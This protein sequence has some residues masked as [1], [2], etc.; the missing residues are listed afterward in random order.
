MGCGPSEADRELF[1]AASDENIEGVRKHLEAGANVNA[2]S[3]NGF[4]PLDIAIL[5][6]RRDKRD[7][8][9]SDLLRSKEAKSGTGAS[10]LVA[11]SLG[12]VQ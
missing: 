8:E 12:D 6:E 1:D 3:K 5:I 10:S 7:N 9:I 11:A 4:T 2:T